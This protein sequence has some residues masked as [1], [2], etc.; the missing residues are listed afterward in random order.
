MRL[1]STSSSRTSLLPVPY[2]TVRLLLFGA[3]LI[4]L[5]GCSSPDGRDS[6]AGDAIQ[7]EVEQQIEELNAMRSSLAQTVTEPDVDKET[8]ARVCKPVGQRAQE[9]AAENNWVV[10]QLAARNRNPDHGLDEEAREVYERFEEEP[11]LVHVWRETRFDGTLGRRYF[12]R[13]TV[14]KSCLACHGPKEER[15]DFVKEGYPEDKAYG[16]EAGDLRGLYAV[17]V[18]DSLRA[19]IDE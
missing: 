1:L 7:A 15:P 8:F 11:E 3:A 9:I 4:G 10:Q 18:P 12:R 17:F 16:F 19:S 13:I 5:V 6:E 2:A 14:E